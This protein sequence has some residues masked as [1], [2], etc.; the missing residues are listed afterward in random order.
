M[1]YQLVEYEI[2]LTRNGSGLCGGP[3]GL[4]T[5]YE[6]DGTAASIDCD[7]GNSRIYYKCTGDNCYGGTFVDVP[8]MCN[9]CAQFGSTDPPGALCDV[10]FTTNKSYSCQC[11]AF[12]GQGL[13]TT[14]KWEALGG[15]V[16]D[17]VDHAGHCPAIVVDHE[18]ACGVTYEGTCGAD[19]EGSEW[20]VC[21]SGA[22]NDGTGQCICEW[23]YPTDCDSGD[24]CGGFNDT[25]TGGVCNVT[26]DLYCDNECFT[27]N[28][29]SNCCEPNL[30]RIL[31]FSS[32]PSPNIELS[33]GEADT[34][35]TAQQFAFGYARGESADYD[36]NHIRLYLRNVTSGAKWLIVE[37]DTEEPDT[38]ETR[39]LS[40]TP[41]APSVS[42]T[43]TTFEYV[44]ETILTDALGDPLL[45]IE[46]GTTFDLVAE[47]DMA[48]NGGVDETVTSSTF[49]ISDDERWGCTD[50]LANNTT[51]NATDDDG[52]CEYSGCAFK[53]AN[54]TADNYT[55]NTGEL[56]ANSYPC[57]DLNGY[58][59]DDIVDDGSCV[60]SPIINVTHVP[61]TVYENGIVTIDASG[62]QAQP[63]E[64]LNDYSFEGGDLTYTWNITDTEG[65]TFTCGDYDS[66]I[67][68][69]IV[70]LYVGSGYNMGGGGIIYADL[71]V[72]NNSGFDE[73]TY[74]IVVGD[75]DI[76]GTQLS[77][78]SSIYIPGGGN[79]SIIGCYMPPNEGGYN[80]GDTLDASFYITNP[81]EDDS[82]VNQDFIIG[83]IAYV[84]V[85]LD[86]NCTADSLLEGFFNYITGVGWIGPNIPLI[87]GMGIYLITGL[88]GYFRW[89]ES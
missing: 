86:S 17:G 4:Q 37:W 26:T 15:C 63:S 67:I 88:P 7:T 48:N 59:E 30:Y 5:G 71:R 62:T 78:F 28:Q 81:D 76:I 41:G 25:A 33:L 8:S 39:W 2:N 75:V 61:S 27:C 18:D 10:F 43:A 32:N 72:D 79:L 12:Y 64:A 1:A 83:D 14:E 68:N 35:L 89:T 3:T 38:C 40:G 85:C 24:P 70:P 42:S 74:P 60:F 49:T 87:P 22:V 16:K 54:T 65:N 52:T 31:N 57:N 66:E 34:T 21:S 56:L 51:P 53:T 45:A 23:G 29:T 80:M 69:C 55:C 9:P 11:N 36:I 47:V 77:E 58:D 82:A 19:C 13:T 6:A 84:K 46:A 50:P 73:L 44:P 20:T